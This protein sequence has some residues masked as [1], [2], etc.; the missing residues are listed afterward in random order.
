MV[1]RL[2][3]D[4]EAV[5][6]LSDALVATGNPSVKASFARLLAFGASLTA[7][8]DVWCR[9]ELERQNLL[10]SPELGYDLLAKR[11]RAVSACL[12]ESLGEV[13]PVSEPLITE[14]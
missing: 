5:R 10:K 13:L 7:E 12:F 14:E 6:V 1:A 11:T 2:R 9:A 8:R 3:R 4:S